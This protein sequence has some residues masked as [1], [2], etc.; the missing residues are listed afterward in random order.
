MALVGEG[1]AG[2][3]A[4]ARAALGGVGV[5]VGVVQGGELGR[6]ITA[7]ASEA[8][9]LGQVLQDPLARVLVELVRPAGAA[10]KVGHRVFG[11]RAHARVESGEDCDQVLR[12]PAAPSSAIHQRCPRLEAPRLDLW[13][14]SV[15]GSNPTTP[16]ILIQDSQIAGVAV[17]ASSRLR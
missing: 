3:V 9:G 8:A 10:I 6:A 1:L 15:V 12:K 5:Q 2:A 7:G 14:I 11:S 4:A 13:G 16:T 17:P